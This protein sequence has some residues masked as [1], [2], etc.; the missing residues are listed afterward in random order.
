MAD[1]FGVRCIFH[2]P[3]GTYEERITI[4]RADTFDEAVAMAEQDAEE[5][6]DEVGSVFLGFA[7]AYVM[8]DEPGQGAEIFSLLRDS[9]LEPDEYLDAFFDTGTEREA[10]LDDSE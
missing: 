9:E 7:Q 4:W 8:P 3:E 2:D 6:A 5:Y 1:W 10:S